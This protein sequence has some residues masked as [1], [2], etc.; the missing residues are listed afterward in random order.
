MTSLFP[1]EILKT[2]LLHFMEV[3]QSIKYQLFMKYQLRPAKCGNTKTSNEVHDKLSG[4][5]LL[6]PLTTLTSRDA[7]TPK[8]LIK[9]S[10]SSGFNFLYLFNKIKYLNIY[11]IN[12]LLMA[13][14]C[15]FLLFFCNVWT[16]FS[17]CYLSRRYW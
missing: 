9:S 4:S 3:L 5:T 2:F 14:N 11:L 12:C 17:P 10:S 8:A 1:C 16:I 15:D 6:L 7:F 13:F